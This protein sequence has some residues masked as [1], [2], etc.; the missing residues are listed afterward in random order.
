MC[1]LWGAFFSLPQAPVFYPSLEL[2]PLSCKFPLP[3]LCEWGVLLILGLWAWPC[4][5]LWLM[6]RG[7]W[8]LQWVFQIS[9]CLRAISIAMRRNVSSGLAQW[10]HEKDEGCLEPNSAS[11][12]SRD[13]RIIQLRVN[14]ICNSPSN[15]RDKFS[16]KCHWLHSALLCKN[17]VLLF[18]L[19][20][21]F[22]WEF[23]LWLSGNESN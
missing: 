23:L 9:Y 11:S 2:C 3:S 21:F 13:K 14:N 12:C 4:D 7:N 8:C 16:V 18:L 1:H 19:K 20:N 22:Y 17:T 10:P 6:E 15:V 5:L